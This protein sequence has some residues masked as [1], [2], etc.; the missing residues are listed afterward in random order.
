MCVLHIGVVGHGELHALG[1]LVLDGEL[2]L[3]DEHCV[4]LLDGGSLHWHILLELICHVA[5][6]QGCGL[7]DH[8]HGE[9]GVPDV[10]SCSSLWRWR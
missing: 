7:V 8:W 9:V 2:L 1:L 5:H 4:L 3:G 10:A 6:G